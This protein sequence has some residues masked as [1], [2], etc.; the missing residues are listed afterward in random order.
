MVKVEKGVITQTSLPLYGYIAGQFVSRMANHKEELL[1]DGWYE[2]EHRYPKY[3][4]A[5]QQLSQPN[6]I[7][8]SELDKVYADYTIIDKPEA[9]L[10]RRID[11]LER[12]DISLSADKVSITADGIDKATIIA[13]FTGVEVDSFNCHI[14]IDGIV[15]DT[16]YPIVNGEVIREFTSEIAKIYKI[17][18]HAGNKMQTIFVEA[19]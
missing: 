10:K 9:A 4:L 7:Y 15:C 11:E 1:K 17:D 16:E 5:Y 12:E 3:D 19:I 18:F 8:D 13:T 6:Y 14:V 2:P